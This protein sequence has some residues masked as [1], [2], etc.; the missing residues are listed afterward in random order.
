MV[1]IKSYNNKQTKIQQSYI[2]YQIHQYLSIR[3][4]TTH[5]FIQLIS[6]II[7]KHYKLL[8]KF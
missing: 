8:T 6:G 7:F 1:K 3:I 2:L 5:I 4:R